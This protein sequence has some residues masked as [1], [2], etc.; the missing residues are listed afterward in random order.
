MSSLPSPHGQHH[1]R[2]KGIEKIC[3]GLD[4][5]GS[6]VKAAVQ[7]IHPGNSAETAPIYVVRFSGEKCAA[8]VAVITSDDSFRWGEA[9]V[10]DWIAQHPKDR[11]SIICQWK[12]LLMPQFRHREV[13]QRTLKALFGD[14][15]DKVD[16]SN[17]SI[18]GTLGV[19]IKA[20]LIHIKSECLAW[21]K[22]YHPSKLGQSPDWDH[23]PWEVQISVPTTWNDDAKNVMV[24]AAQEA[25]FAFSNIRDETE[26]VAATYMR[27]L[28]ENRH[29]KQ[30]DTILLSDIGGG[31][32]DHCKCK[33]VV[34][35]SGGRRMRLEIV[36]SPKGNEAGSSLPNDLAWNYIKGCD[37]VTSSHGSL[38]GVLRKL[39]ISLQECQRQVFR[40]IEQLKVTFSKAPRSVYTI[41]ISGPGADALPIP[42]KYE[43]V[44][45][46]HD[47]WFDEIWKLLGEVAC[48]TAILSGAG[49]KNNYLRGRLQ[50]SLRSKGIAVMEEPV[51]S[52]CSCGALQH[53]LFEKDAPLENQRFYVTRLE[54]VKK[55]SQHNDRVYER[56]KYDKRRYYQ[57]L[58]PSMT[59]V[60]GKDT[61]EHPPVRMDFDMEKEG[62]IYVNVYSSTQTPYYD[63]CTPLHDPATGEQM[64]NLRKHLSAFFETSDV[65]PDLLEKLGLAGSKR[66]RKGKKGIRYSTVVGDVSLEK[67]GEDVNLIVK[68]LE[69]GTSDVADTLTKPIHNPYRSNTLK[70]DSDNTDS[71]AL[72]SSPEERSSPGMITDTL[73][74]ASTRDRA[75]SSVTTQGAL[76][77]H[78]FSLG[79]GPEVLHATVGNPR[80]DLHN[81]SISPTFILNSYGERHDGTA[82]KIKQLGKRT[83]QN[84]TRPK[85][86]GKR[87]A[88]LLESKDNPSGAKRVVGGADV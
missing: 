49:V 24:R 42:I 26:C 38:R 43:E 27:K 35:P 66:K 57:A 79:H 14:Q 30:G 88:N 31:T 64:A 34:A 80:N 20:H 55:E 1:L 53:F 15:V 33:L 19:V 87:K 37:T 59:I 5:G 84:K 58:H 48:Q 45:R 23:M 52:S 85:S 3:L 72:E 65:D 60:N 78:D 68:L 41:V 61:S 16:V 6:S 51:D 18:L 10:E 13:V 74:D 2:P 82:N 83:P 67:V 54:Q 21:C 32:A 39:R 12:M 8:Q 44:K 40:E 46:W 25:G 47:E 29:I 17:E 77:S 50:A 70:R 71:R 36:G 62:R 75:S 73:D 11:E 9:Q 7:H 81:P 56:S 69:P 76:D 86:W 63:D 4:Y 22:T 28:Y